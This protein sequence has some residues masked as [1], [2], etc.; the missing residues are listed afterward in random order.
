MAYLH[1][2]PLHINPAL[3][4]ADPVAFRHHI[5][6]VRSRLQEMRSPCR[7]PEIDYDFYYQKEYLSTCKSTEKKAPAANT[8]T[9]FSSP[10]PMT[11]PIKMSP[12]CEDYVDDNV[13]LVAEEEHAVAALQNT[14]NVNVTFPAKNIL[15]VWY[16]L[17]FTKHYSLRRHHS[18]IN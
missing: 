9:I 17:F 11:S 16:A 5:G 10:C 6:G 4:L 7:T 12:L 1:Y 13:V 15:Q 3:S 2:L 14:L 8:H 18:S